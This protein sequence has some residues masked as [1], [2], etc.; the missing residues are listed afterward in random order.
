MGNLTSQSR[1]RTKDYVKPSEGLTLKFLERKSIGKLLEE[2]R[3]GA[4]RIAIHRLEER[5]NVYNKKSPTLE[6]SPDEI[7]S[8]TE[9]NWQT[10]VQW[11]VNKSFSW[12]GTTKHPTTTCS[13]STS[14][15]W[16][17]LESESSI[18]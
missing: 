12:F 9:L 16:I 3:S 18:R 7:S 8:C 5:L 14:D 13:T 4:K 6:G 15:S 2:D 10:R 17:E 11:S 1:H